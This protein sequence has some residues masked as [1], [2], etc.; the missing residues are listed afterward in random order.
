MRG[1]K[2]GVLSPQPCF[3]PLLLGEHR[4]TGTGS[5]WAGEQSEA[6]ILTASNPEGFLQKQ[7]AWRRGREQKG[8]ASLQRGTGTNHGPC[9]D[10]WREKTALVMLREWHFRY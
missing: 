3:L 9:R 8:K 7:R 10:V 1:T 5:L 6:A 2:D 4:F